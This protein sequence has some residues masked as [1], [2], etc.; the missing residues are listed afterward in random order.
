MSCSQKLRNGYM[1]WK[2]VKAPPACSAKFIGICMCTSWSW[3][4]PHF[5]PERAMIMPPWPLSPISLLPPSYCDQGEDGN[6][7]Q[8]LLGPASLSRPHLSHLPHILPSSHAWLK[9]RECF[10]SL[11]EWSV[12]SSSSWILS[13]LPLPAIASQRLLPST[14]LNWTLYHLISTQK[15]L[16]QRNLLETLSP[17]ISFSK[18]SQ[19]SVFVSWH[20]FPV[21]ANH[22]IQKYA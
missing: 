6:P 18:S 11:W 20:M 9:V 8:G 12:F 19:Y 4:D 2:S 14:T 15:T 13:M 10:F 17:Q 21:F 7:Y 16:P 5:L 3:K 1:C 22:R